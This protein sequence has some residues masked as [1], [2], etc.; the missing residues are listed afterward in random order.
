MLG[1]LCR[2]QEY[3]VYTGEAGIM[4]RGESDSYI[5]NGKEKN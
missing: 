3:F 5:M 2:T 4:I 1:I